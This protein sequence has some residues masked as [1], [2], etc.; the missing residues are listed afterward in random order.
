MSDPASRAHSLADV[1]PAGGAYRVAGEGCA[2]DYTAALIA[3]LGGRVTRVR[4][5]GAELGGRQ[6]RRIL[7]GRG[8]RSTL[9][10]IREAEGQVRFLGSGSGHGVGLSQWGARELARQGKTY[11]EI[12][13]HYYSG[14]NFERLGGTETAS[15]QWSE[16]R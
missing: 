2:A 1:S 7:G 14:T 5:G 3:S 10:D 6:L 12:L 4:V 13:S 8:L 16:I 9:F 15:T 11:R